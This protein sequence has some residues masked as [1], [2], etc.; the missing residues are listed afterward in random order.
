M[1]ALQNLPV[2]IDRT[3]PS[4]L[5]AEECTLGSILIDATMLPFVRSIL[6]PDDFYIVKYGW[7]F[8][9]MLDLDMRGQPID[10]VT[11]IEELERRGQL[12]EA[13]G[14]PFVASLTNR[15]PVALYATGYAR[16]VEVAS[17]RRKLLLNF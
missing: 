7:V 6:K 10:H 8:A 9:A 12:A 1:I 14:P 11:V 16:I 2:T 17:I 4:A 5:E 15:V 13:G 3:E